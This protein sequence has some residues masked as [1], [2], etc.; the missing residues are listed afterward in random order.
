MRERWSE[1]RRSICK[2][3]RQERKKVNVDE[4]EGKHFVKE[5]ILSIIYFGLVARLF[6]F[7]CACF[8]LPISLFFP[9]PHPFSLN[10]WSVRFLS[11]AVT[12]KQLPSFKEPIRGAPRHQVGRYHKREFKLWLKKKKKKE[13]TLCLKQMND[14]KASSYL[15]S[16]YSKHAALWP[17]HFCAMLYQESFM[18]YLFM[19][20]IQ[21]LIFMPL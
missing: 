11:H 2:S 21:H 4:E 19:F 15:T 20:L 5:N 1:V 8:P 9:L 16:P 10:N 12:L 3:T 17:T 14:V 6:P 13:K 18:T 7:C